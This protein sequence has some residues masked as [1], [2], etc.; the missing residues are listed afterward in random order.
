MSPI[1][2]SFATIPHT[3]Y[4]EIDFSHDGAFLA[5]GAEDGIIQIWRINTSLTNDDTGRVRILHVD[6]YMQQL[7]NANSVKKENIPE[8]IP[9]YEQWIDVGVCLLS[10]H[11]DYCIRS[12]GNIRLRGFL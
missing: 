4:Y 3:G 5:V 2:R 1:G 7:P 8:P 9:L 11:K 10:R 12:Q 6:T